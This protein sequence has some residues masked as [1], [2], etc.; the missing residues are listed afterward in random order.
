MR[1]TTAAAAAS[2]NCLEERSGALPPLTAA[3]VADGELGNKTW[4]KG[5]SSSLALSPNFAYDGSPK[6]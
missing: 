5:S 2:G 1:A 6:N 3:S 4:L